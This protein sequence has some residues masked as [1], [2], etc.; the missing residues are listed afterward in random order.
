M[1]HSKPRSK[2][3]SL[4]TLTVDL[5]TELTMLSMEYETGKEENRLDRVSLLLDLCQL[6][7]IS[8]VVLHYLRLAAHRD[9]V[10]RHRG[11]QNVSTH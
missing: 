11:T 7:L 10:L 3:S 9:R 5:Q 4:T 2:Q 6:V 8:H 1:L